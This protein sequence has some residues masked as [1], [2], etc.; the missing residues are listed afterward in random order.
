MSL[1]HRQPFDICVALEIGPKTP[2]ADFRN[3]AVRQRMWQAIILLDA[4]QPDRTPG[5]A[6]CGWSSH[7]LPSAAQALSAGQDVEE[8]AAD[9]QA[10]AEQD[11]A[12]E[13]PAGQVEE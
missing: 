9:E 3:P 1:L 6:I 8:S 10:E 4:G 11:K 2:E 7:R 5:D 12:P 13:L